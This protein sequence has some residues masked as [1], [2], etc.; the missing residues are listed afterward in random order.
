M[1]NLV[2]KITLSCF[3]LSSINTVMGQT[4]PNI[5]FIIVDD[6]GYHDISSNGSKIYQTPNIDKLSNNSVSFSNAYS[7][8]PRCVPSRAGIMTGKYPVGEDKG[9]LGQ[10]AE[11]KNFIKQFKTAGYNSFYVGKWHLGSDENS[12]KGFGFDQSFA[13][14]DPG[15]TESHFYPFNLKRIQGGKDEEAPVPDVEKYAREGD[16]LA[17][18]LTKRTIEYIKENKSGKPFIGVLATFAVH[19]P[20]EA[21]KVD[22]ERNQKEIENF[23]FGTTPEWQKEGHAETKMRQDSPIYAGMV[24]NMDENIG[25]LIQQLKDQ[26]IYDNTIIVLTSDHGGLST[27]GGKRI[28]ATTNSPLR[29]GKGWLYEGGVRVP[30]LLHLPNAAKSFVDKES[31]VMGMDIFPT[32]V[33]L[34]LNKKISG[35]DGKSFKNVL[36]KKEIWNQRTVY[37]NSYKARPTQTG[38]DKTS[39]IRVGD[40]KLLHFIETDKVELYN[41][42]KD[43][44]E[45][46]DLAAIMPDKKQEMLVLLNKWKEAENIT[47]KPN[48]IKK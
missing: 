29:A 5:L 20:L 1:K 10:I 14:G 19:T 37:W 2:F 27:R 33:D 48:H 12:P 16:Y 13:A 30:L 34:A 22:I 8:Y 3:L 23:D 6:F 41:I 31:I 38:D 9:N 25:K 44:S 39:A 40:Y 24:E 17:D 15:A 47:M 18:V 46:N 11:D 28:M 7:C 4:K 45:K 32:L 36:L 42:K 26:G 35:I 43:I 21:K